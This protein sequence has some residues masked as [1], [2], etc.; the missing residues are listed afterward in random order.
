MELKNNKGWRWSGSE[1]AAYGRSGGPA[2]Y[3]GW[4]VAADPQERCSTLGNS[5]TVHVFTSRQYV[6]A[7][8]TILHDWSGASVPN[9]FGR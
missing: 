6:P 2:D 8:W 3:N 7:G 1:H 9:A 4:I 5:D